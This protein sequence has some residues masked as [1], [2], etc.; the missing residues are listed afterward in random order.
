M[1]YT[2]LEYKK[3]RGEPIDNATTVYGEFREFLRD[4]AIIVAQPGFKLLDIHEGKTETIV[5]IEREV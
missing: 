1:D 2:I 4:F 5:V 3:R